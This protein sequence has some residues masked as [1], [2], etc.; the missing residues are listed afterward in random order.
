MDKL[1]RR[2]S[3]NYQLICHW[4]QLCRV[5]KNYIVV[6]WRDDQKSATSSSNCQFRY[7]FG[8]KKEQQ[9]R[10][11]SVMKSRAAVAWEAGKPLVIEE[12]EVAAAEK[13]EGLVEVNGRGGCTT[14]A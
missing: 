4:C 8:K 11:R 10:L 5:I 1:N 13:G 7:Y 2:Q 9:N 6:L 3:R 12:V 14:H